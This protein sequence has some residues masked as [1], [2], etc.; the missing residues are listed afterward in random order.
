MQ[1]F[2]DESVFD[3]FCPDTIQGDFMKHSKKGSRGP[4]LYF[5][6]FQNRI[7]CAFLLCTLIPIFI[8]GGIS[9]AVS[10]NIAK[11]KILNASISADAQLH[12]QFDNRLQQ[13]EN[14]ADTLQYNMYN[15]M[16]ADAPMDTLA[17]LS[18][19]RSNLYMF[20]TSFDLAYIN[21]FL[22]DEH[23]ASS[24]S[25]YFFPVSKLSDFQIPKEVL[26]NPGTSSVWFYQD[27]LSV[28]FLVNNSYHITNSVS[29]CRVLKHPDT[30]SIKYAYIIYLDAS[31]FSSILQEIFQD[32]Q[33]TSYILTDNGKIV[34]SNNPSLLSASLDE[35]KLD[36]LYNKGDSLKKRAHTNYHT[37]TLRNGWLQVTEIPDSYI[38][39]NTHILI[40]SILL[41][42]LISL[43]LT[44]LVVVLISKNLTRRIKTLSR[45][46]ETLQLDASDTNMKALVPQDRAPETFDEIDKLGITFEKMQHS[47]ND[48]LQSILELS[49]TEERLKYQ[50]LQSQINPHFLY[51]ILLSIQTCQSLGK[52]DIANQM[53]TNLTRF[54]RMTLRK[55]EDLISIRDELTIAQLYLEMEKLCHNDNLTW[56]INMEDGID[57]F[58]ICKFTL[59]PFLENSIMHG[60]SQK[61]PEVHISIDLSYGDDT[62]IIVIT[63]NGIGMAKEQLLEL[64]KTL[65]EKIV[66]YEKHFG[67]GNVNKRISNPYFGNGRISVESC[68]YEGTS[69]TIEFDQMEKYDEECNDCR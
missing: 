40:K 33:I 31:E 6:H 52:L 50:L 58:L 19:I 15:L 56:E 42:I 18:E 14:I 47:L 16:Q 57:N 7:L 23:M 28:P 5:S 39:Q 55:S 4:R 59:Q 11:D 69:I 43:P 62:V 24:E 21:I 48:N 13:V 44:I 30:D 1:D 2:I 63:D 65:D 29:C 46:M 25:L 27:L 3:R 53:L 17:M 36:F 41:T 26:E 10:Y 38:M 32:N 9:Y 22:P 49:L 60:L 67:I 66:N 35:E 54:Y 37:T 20:K 51:N 61:T 34:A 8:I 64:Q 68:L 12:T 45:A